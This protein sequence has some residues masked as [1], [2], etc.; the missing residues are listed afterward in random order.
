ML[1][2]IS[3]A[4]VSSKTRYLQDVSYLVL[5]TTVV[6]AGVPGGDL[7][8]WEEELLC[9]SQSHACFVEKA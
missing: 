3:V 5:K 2:L 8:N 6:V 7:G 4:C 9:N 1:I